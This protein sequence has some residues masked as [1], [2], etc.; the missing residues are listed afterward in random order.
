MLKQHMWDNKKPL[1]MPSVK[2]PRVNEISMRMKKTNNKFILHVHTYK[3]ENN[4]RILKLNTDFIWNA[5]F[6][7][8]KT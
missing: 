5:S 7:G 2:L 8:R 1:H 3:L 4:Q 6:C